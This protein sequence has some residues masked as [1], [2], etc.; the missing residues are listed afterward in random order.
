MSE[1]A[2]GQTKDAW[3]AMLFSHA[4]VVRALEADLSTYSDLPL[5]W[6]E[7]LNRLDEAPGQ[8]RRVHELADASLFT[9][10][11]L[12]RL[13]DRM[14]AAGLVLREHSALDRRGV[15]ICLTQAGIDELASIWPQFSVSIQRHFGRHLTTDD[16]QALI[17][18]TTKIL[19]ASR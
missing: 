19:N 3:K 5:T 6:F 4:Q 11:G 1:Q 13:V 2:S 16:T 12:T 9:R 8:R 14:E 15:Y 18:A 17:V 10:S 7:V